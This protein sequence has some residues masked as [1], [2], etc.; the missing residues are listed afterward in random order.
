MGQCD[1]GL[2]G[3]PELR[4]LFYDRILEL[5]PGRHA[6]ATKAISIGDEFLPDHYSRRPLMP[7]TL[8]LESLAQVGGWLYI[9]SEGF[10][11]QCVLGMVEGVRIHRPVP[12]GDTLLLEVWLEY[13]HR[14]GATLR[15]EARSG[16]QPLLSVSRMM[17]AS[18]RMNNPA[19]V[20]RARELFAYLSG[21]F[22]VNGV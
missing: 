9:V 13:R 16:R 2:P 4:F 7:A 19:D 8:V 3:E 20:R 6:L 11:I 1:L 17:F 12:V 15:A 21:G 14:D 18:E 22:E 5:Q 10:G